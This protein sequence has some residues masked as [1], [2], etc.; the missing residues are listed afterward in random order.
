MRRYGC[1]AWRTASHLTE[2]PWNQA[3][4]SFSVCVDTPFFYNTRLD[5]AVIRITRW[6]A[7]RIKSRHSQM[8]EFRTTKCS[9]EFT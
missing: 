6:M 3:A 7:N 2:G 9:T 8:R 5:F 4:R 1:V